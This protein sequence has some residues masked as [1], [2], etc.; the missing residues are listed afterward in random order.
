MKQSKGD[1]RMLP[2][3]I[4]MVMDKLCKSLETRLPDTVKS[5]YLYGS[6]ALHAYIAGSSD[7]DFLAIVNRTLTPSDLSLILEA[8]QVVELNVPGLD[9]MGAYIKQEDLGEFPLV[10]TYHDKILQPDGGG[11]LNPVTWWVLRK[12]GICVYGEHVSFNYDISPDQLVQYVIE[13]MDTYWVG[14]I[15]RLEQKINS[16]NLSDQTVPLEQLDF[17]VEWCT[18]GMLRQYYTIRERDVTSKTG[19]GEYG[20]TLFPQRWHGLIREAVSI[21]RKKPVREYASQMNRLADL[22]EFLRL[23]HTE[24][25]RLSI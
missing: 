12:Y 4:A 15:N 20:L 25:H 14:W 24:S 1:D 21:K 16:T 23:I 10:P 18:L 6:T 5:V 7:I 2:E 19:A 13:N 22:T 3:Y 11:D 17:A 9:I 8:H